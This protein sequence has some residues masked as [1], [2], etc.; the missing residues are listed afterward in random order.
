MFR[1]RWIPRY[2][3]RSSSITLRRTPVFDSTGLRLIWWW[4]S[5]GEVLGSRRRNATGGLTILQWVV[6]HVTT[7]QAAVFINLV[8]AINWLA[9]GMSTCECDWLQVCLPLSVVGCRCVHQ[10]VWL[11]AGVSTC[12]CDWLQVCL[13]VS[14]IGCR[15]VYQWVW[16]IAGVL[17]V[18]EMM[19]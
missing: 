18:H 19:F 9:T 2:G 6:C 5:T 16:L 11:A 12:D 3:G 7:V 10:W 1:W 14:V 4:R 15:C 17:T 13:P 8:A